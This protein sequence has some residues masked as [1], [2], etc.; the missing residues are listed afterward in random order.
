M[1]HYRVYVLDE[2]G[3]LMAVV[4]LDCIDDD[5]AKE[6]AQRLANGNEVELWRLVTRFNS[7]ERK[8]VGSR[9]RRNVVAP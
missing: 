8:P 1:P 4:N 9:Q 6:C 3:R 5:A 2:P 7:L